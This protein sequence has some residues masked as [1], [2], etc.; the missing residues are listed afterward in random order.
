TAATGS[1]TDGSVSLGRV[2]Q[3]NALGQLTVT[4][5]TGTITLHGNLSTTPRAAS[6]TTGH[7]TFGSFT[8]LTRDT[9]LNTG[10]GVLDFSAV[11]VFADPAGPWTFTVNSA[12]GNVLLHNFT[13]T[14]GV[15]AGT[16]VNTVTVK[17]AGGQLQLNGSI[18]LDKKAAQTGDFT[19]TGGG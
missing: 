6:G 15:I 18:A 16:F 19:F 2:G 1:T 4:A 11:T 17:A 8:E 13:D 14:D 9:V 3:L 12:G 10:G 7:I 5:H